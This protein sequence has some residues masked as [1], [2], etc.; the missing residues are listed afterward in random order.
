MNIRAKVSSKGQVVI[1]KQIREGLGITDGTEVEF[2]PQG[3]GFL[4][5]PVDDFD[6]RYPKAPAGALL[7]H[8]VRTA[9]PFPSDDEI[10]RAMLAEAAR[11]FD[12]TRR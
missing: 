12:A 3:G 9:K 2:I 4:V 6:P 10:D 11:R 1:P 8:V 5:Q 7:K